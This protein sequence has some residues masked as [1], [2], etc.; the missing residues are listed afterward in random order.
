[1]SSF[2]FLIYFLIKFINFASSL[3]AIPINKHF[4]APLAKGETAL[5]SISS[6]QTLALPF[7]ANLSNPEKSFAN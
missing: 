2:T 5:L 1:V 6:V 7:L 3:A 4:N